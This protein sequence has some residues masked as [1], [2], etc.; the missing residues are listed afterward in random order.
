MRQPLAWSPLTRQLLAWCPLT[1][2]SLTRERLTRQPIAWGLLTSQ[3]LQCSML[4]FLSFHKA[5]TCKRSPA[6]KANNCLSSAYDQITCSP[7]MGQYLHELHLQYNGTTFMRFACGPFTRQS[8]AWGPLTRQP[9]AWG[10]PTH[11][12]NTSIWKMV[13]NVQNL[14]IFITF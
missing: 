2:Q 6:H 4:N 10:P 5:T 7:L 13:L 9:L 8:F 11:K 14:F 1:R 3:P 12:E